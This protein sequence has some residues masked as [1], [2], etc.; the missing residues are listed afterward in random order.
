MT[1][2]S[3]PP[4]WDPDASLQR[5]WQICLDLGK[6]R[7]EQ[8]LAQLLLPRK[9]CEAGTGAV[10]GSPPPL[11]MASHLPH[12]PPSHLYYPTLHL[13]F[14]P[15]TNPSYPAPSLPPLADSACRQCQPSSLS[16]ISISHLS[17]AR[18]RMIRQY[19]FYPWRQWPPQAIS[20]TGMWS[21]NPK[22]TKRVNQT[23]R[24]VYWAT[25]ITYIRPS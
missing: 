23:T 12:S 7:L 10:Q 4:L 16:P 1:A 3:L 22:M 20:Q 8:T 24:M 17:L 2:L 5:R 13:P 18:S 14:H 25:I 9:T 11:N 19:P 21:P 15:P 6:C